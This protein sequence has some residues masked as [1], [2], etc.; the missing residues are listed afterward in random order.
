MPLR[1]ASRASIVFAFCCVYLCWGMTYGAIHIAVE[2]IAPPLVGAI[3][4]LLSL[5]IFVAICWTRR[6]S[7]RVPWQTAWRLAVVGVLI[8]SV[9]NVLLIWAESK[10]ASGWASVVIALVPVMVAVIESVLPHSET[11]TVRGWVGTLVSAAGILALLWPSLHGF[12]ATGRS[13]GDRQTL[14]GFLILVLAALSFA[15]GSIL[16]RRFHF[17]LDTFVATAWEIGAASL[18]NSALALAGGNLR[19]AHFTRGGLLSILFL[20]V[21]GSLVGLTAYTYLLQYVPVT[22]VSTYAFV[23]PMIAVL[24]GA[25]FFRERLGA[26]EVAGMLLILGGVAMVILSRTRGEQPEAAGEN[27]A[28]Q[29]EA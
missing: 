3:R 9:N 16:G 29:A 14:V 25:A 21:F 1:A 19:T 4:S 26:A 18:V 6:V 13:G 7:L 27:V 22:K 12:S 28:L 10:V 17:R 20:A 15:C 23:N 5:G 24:I 11:L 2:H 8:M